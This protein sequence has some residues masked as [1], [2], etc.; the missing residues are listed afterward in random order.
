MFLIRRKPDNHGTNKDKNHPYKDSRQL[1]HLHA[2]CSSCLEMLYEGYTVYII[3]SISSHGVQCMF[4]LLSLLHLPVTVHLCCSVCFSG[5]VFITD[6]VKRIRYLLHQGACNNWLLDCI[7]I[8]RCAPNWRKVAITCRVFS[9]HGEIPLDPGHFLLHFLA[10]HAR[11][12][13]SNAWIESL[14]ACARVCVCVS[15]GV[16]IAQTL[17]STCQGYPY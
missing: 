5:T 15:G 4:H 16:C 3:V 9:L 11:I 7:C 17:M 6:A 14:C 8:V 13:D 1:R 10:T 2:V 12:K